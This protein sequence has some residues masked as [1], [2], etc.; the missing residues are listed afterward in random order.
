M[1][2]SLELNLEKYHA[3]LKNSEWTLC[4]GAG[5]C[6]KILPNWMELTRRV[7]NICFGLNWDK[8]KFV[9]ETSKIGFSLDGWLQA[10]LNNYLNI[11]K[12]LNDF[13]LILE[14]QLYCDL[15]NQAEKEGHGNTISILLNDPTRLNKEQLLW[16][17]DFFEKKYPDSTLLQLKNV[18]LNESDGII[19]PK[20]IIT[21]NA[22]S[23]LY[24]FLV[25]YSVKQNFLKTND[26]NFHFQKYVRVIRPFE[27]GAIKTPICHLHGAIFPRPKKKSRNKDD[28]RDNLIFAETSY[29]KIAGA[30]HSWAQNSFL[31]HATNTKMVFIGLSMSDPN[32]RRWL[33]WSTDN[34]N[35]Q[36]EAFTGKP[37]TILRHIWIKNQTKGCRNTKINRAVLKTF[38][39][40][41]S[42]DR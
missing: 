5:V 2:D 16:A 17:C 4:L 13:Y 26:Y 33:S 28:S 36:L 14:E 19:K 7:V 32:I 12:S 11:G 23:L 27:V 24:S 21:F 31:Y 35:T 25:I 20:T 8:N 38:I 37:Q 3:Y 10:S 34:L 39:Y 1:N 18:L 30:M 40:K 15:I 41:I 42:M 6:D 22:D 9:I 29:T